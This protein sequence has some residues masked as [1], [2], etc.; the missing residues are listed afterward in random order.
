[1]KNRSIWGIFFNPSWEKW[2][3]SIKLTWSAWQ[4]RQ[5]STKKLT[6]SS[7]CYNSTLCKKPPSRQHIHNHPL[8]NL[9][10]QPK[11]KTK[12]RIRGRQHTTLQSHGVRHV[13][14]NSEPDASTHVGNAVLPR[15]KNKITRRRGSGGPGLALYPIRH[16]C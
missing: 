16:P 12:I 4:Q 8:S 6:I 14:A 10:R 1:M 3:V 5:H 7:I 11:G 13:A 9:T 2:P 15:Q